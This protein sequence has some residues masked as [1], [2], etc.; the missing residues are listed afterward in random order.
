VIDRILVK[1]YVNQS[2][3]LFASCALVLF[4]FAWVR[5][6]VGTFFNL[7]E[8]EVIFEQFADFEQYSPVEFAA[9]LTYAGQVGMVYEEPIVIA[10]IVIWCVA[11]GSDV[12]SGELGRGTLEMLLSQPV[13]RQRLLGSHA[14]VSIAGLALLCLL[15]WA[16]IGLGIQTN[17]V[18][19]EIPPPAIELPILNWKISLPGSEPIVEQVPLR[20]R[21][22][23]I[24]YA[25]ATFHLFAFG[26]FILSLAT[27]ISS[28]DRYR[29]R[30][31]GTVVGIY[32]VQVVMFALGLVSKSLSWM[33]GFT[34]LSCYKPQNM[35]AL[36]GK[37]S[38]AA[39]WRLTD[40][41]PD[42]SLP[43]LVY[44]LILLV[45]G[46]SFYCCATVIFQRRD[47]PAPL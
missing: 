7:T 21:V 17:V 14:L 46:V 22:N 19:E 9:L 33:L 38:L 6:W 45:I 35:T 25:A 11:R 28:I 31:V 5:V 44:P 15:V 43:P 4:V 1:K 36:I 23:A 30:T 41:P 42:F 8:Y 27:L 32:V 29:W 12:V 34:F 24:T 3:L 40:T 18:S 37:E 47:L 10:C 16:G 20:E 2:S 39:P 13:S 26:F